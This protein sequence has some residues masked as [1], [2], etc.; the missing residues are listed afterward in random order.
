MPCISLANMDIFRTADHAELLP[1]HMA[2][3]SNR[4]EIACHK[5]ALRMAMANFLTPD[6]RAVLQAYYWDRKTLR[7][8]GDNLGISA[9]AVHK[10]I[11][12]A[13]NT[14]REHVDFCVR[15]YQKIKEVSLR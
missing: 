11:R 13:E 12:R 4:D 1:G 14:L 3:P 10:R 6:Q 9:V 2:Q 8:I 7:E 15:V 5:I